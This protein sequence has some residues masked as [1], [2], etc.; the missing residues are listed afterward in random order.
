MKE[1]EDIED[2][3]N[4]D[5][6]EKMINQLGRDRI[7]DLANTASILGSWMSDQKYTIAEQL[8]II[9]LLRSSILVNYIQM[10]QKAGMET[11]MKEHPEAKIIVVDAQKPPEPRQPR[12]FDPDSS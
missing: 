3:N 5:K 10:Q 2:E 9:E 4:G 1:K 11:F 8:S 6:M 12:T 7:D